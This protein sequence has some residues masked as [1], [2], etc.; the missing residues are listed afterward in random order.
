MVRQDVSWVWQGD[1]ASEP[2]PTVAWDVDLVTETATLSIEA[3][4][5]NFGEYTAVK[6]SIP[7]T[8]G[9]VNPYLVNTWDEL[10]EGILS[11]EATFSW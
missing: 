6:Y 8:I 11:A 5:D 10:T 4:S 7:V 3:T 9:S 1:G 2:Y